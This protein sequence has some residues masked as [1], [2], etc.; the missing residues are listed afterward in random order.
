M[1]AERSQ[2]PPANKP[3]DPLVKTALVLCIGLIVITVV[4]MILTAPDRSIP[5]YSVVAQQ[6][7]VVTVNV[8]PRTTEAEI[9]ALLVRFRVVGHEDRNGFAKLKIKPTT[10][11]DPSGLYQR[12]T[13]YIFNDIGLAEEPVLR[14][15]L[16]GRDPAA[17]HSFVR[18][19]RGV[20]RLT[21]DAE[22]GALGFVPESPAA[23]VDPTQTK[24]PRVFFQG[25]IGQGQG[26][27][28]R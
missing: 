2:I 27:G 6:G 8:P 17:K 5:P 24:A 23:I 4:G 1:E 11:E 21:P 12:L 19:V 25:K 9:E 7:K 15:Y 3:L 20:Y 22:F 14:E 16:A 26:Q 28:V 10:P 18:G 13:I